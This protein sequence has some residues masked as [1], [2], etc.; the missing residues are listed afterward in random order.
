MAD[1]GVMQFELY[2][3]KAPNTVANFVELAQSGFYNGLTFHR[4][5]QDYVIQGG[6]EDNTCMCESSFTIAGEFTANGMDTG[7]VHDRG[8]ISMA[9]DDDYDSAGTQFF[10]VHKPAHKLDGKYA[11]FGMMTEGFD[12]LDVIATTPTLPPEQE[13]RP[14][15][16]Q[17][18]Q[19][20]RIDLNGQQLGEPVRKNI[21]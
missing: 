5:V 20:I 18:I 16:P 7:L 21:C 19:S 12:V 13:N 6:S 4:V 15:T 9:R 2:P 11:A 17:V 8:A 3:D 1:G 14:L 10:V